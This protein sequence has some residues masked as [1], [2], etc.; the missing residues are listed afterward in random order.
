MF[1]ATSLPMKNH[2]FTAPRAASSTRRNGKPS[3]RSSFSSASGPKARK[4]PPT[5]WASPIHA[6]TATG[7]LSASSITSSVRAGPWEPSAAWGATV[8]WSTRALSS[9]YSWPCSHVTTNG[10][11]L[12]VMTRLSTILATLDYRVRRAMV[13][14]DSPSATRANPS[15]RYRL[16]AK[17][18][19]ST[20]RLIRACPCVPA[21]S[22][23]PRRRAR[24]TPRARQSGCTPMISSERRRRRSRTP[25][26]SAGARD[27][28]PHPRAPRV[29]R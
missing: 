23:T 16:R 20:L 29:H 2:S 27:T 15:A 17:L 11:H 9:W 28:R 22:M 3:R 14:R 19:R 21:S 10:R 5:P 12:R 24:P 7:G 25:A 1:A 4:S 18:S 8:R 26:H 6:R 13:S